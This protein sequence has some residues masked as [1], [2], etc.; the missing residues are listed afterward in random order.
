MFTYTN[1]VYAPKRKRNKKRKNDDD[2]NNN[3]NNKK[4]NHQGKIKRKIETMRAH[5]TPFERLS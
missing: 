1:D 2:N 3:K 5:R 4:R